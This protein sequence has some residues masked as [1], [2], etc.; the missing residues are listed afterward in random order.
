MNECTHET[1]LLAIWYPMRR[2]QVHEREIQGRMT[3]GPEVGGK[4]IG[5]L[6][7][8]ELP[9]VFGD[10]GTVCGKGSGVVGR[11]FIRL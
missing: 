8:L 11:A 2:D 6:M 5:R 3:E 1:A 9:G 10:G 7:L 4:K